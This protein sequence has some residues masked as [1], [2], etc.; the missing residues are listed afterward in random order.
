[1][2]HAANDR[3]VLVIGWDAAD[4]RVI[5]PMLA[6]GKL[7]NL[8]KLMDEGVHGNNSTLYPVLSPMLWTSIA[9][10][11]RPFKHGIHGFSEPTPDGSGVR[12]IT[13]ISRKTKAIWNILQQSGKR[14]VV[15]GWWP[16]HP[17]EPID[18]VMVSNHFQRAGGLKNTKIDPA[19]GKPAAGN[20]GWTNDQWPMSPG[21][22]HPPEMTRNLQEFRFHP[23]ELEF[24]HVAPFIPEIGKIDQ[25]KDKRLEGF[26]KTLADTVSIQG[27]S[28][29]LQQLEEWD[30]MCVYFDGIDH[31]CH[32]F[33]KY[34]PPRQE[35]VPE[36]DFELYKGV[37][38]GAYRFHDMMLG[39]T[40][41]LAGE[42]AT[43]I[44][45]SDHGFHPD[46]LRPQNIPT[47]PAGPAIE[48]R[49]YGI[50]VMKG[51]GI[52][53]GERIN[54]A[55]VLD[56]CPTVLTLFGLPVGLDMDGK[57]LVSAF[58]DPVEVRTIQSWDAVDGDC[59]MHPP[60]AHLD[61]MESADAIKQLVDLGYI[62][63]PDEDIGIA[64]RN[65]VQELKYNLARAYMDASLY[66]KAI[67]LLEEIWEQASEEHR[68]GLKLLTCLEAVGARDERARV[69]ERL[70]MNVRE[71]Q[72]LALAEFSGL[73]EEAAPHGVFLST[74]E[75]IEHPSGLSA[76]KWTAST[77]QLDPDTTY[78]EI[79]KKLAH[80]I[81]T[82]ATLLCPMRDVFNWL[83][84]SQ[85]LL[86]DDPK[87][88]TPFL[89]EMAKIKLNHPDL[90]LQVGTGFL[91]LDLH[92]DARMAFKRALDADSENAAAHLGI[93]RA[94]L[95]LGDLDPAVDHALHATEL[96]FFSPQSH[97]VLG[98][99]LARIGN[100]EMARAALDVALKQ[101]PGYHQAHLEMAELLES[102]FE[103]RE[104]A[105]AHRAAARAALDVASASEPD[106]H[107]EMDRII[108]EIAD[109]RAKRKT[110]AGNNE[111]WSMVPTDEIITIVSGLPRS[112]TSMMMQCLNAGGLQPFTDGERVADSDNPRGYF[113][114]EKAT[115]LGRDRSWLSKVRGK[116]VK[117]MAQL[118][119]MLPAD[120]KYRI[121]FM[122]RDLQEIA[123][124]QQAMLDRLGNSGSGLSDDR[125][126]RTFDAQ[127]A[128]VEAWMAESANIQCLFVDYSRTLD[129]PSS[130]MHE[131]NLFLGGSLDETM[132]KSAIDRSL[133]RQDSSD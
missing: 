86:G 36:E 124:S 39:A 26:A 47:E 66:R 22:V 51:P 6:E 32:G 7:P 110:A 46:H 93:A 63:E 90:H 79:P 61:A 92:E 105:E 60:D 64:V 116:S 21:T 53:R 131:V 129:D 82:R 117:I 11:K 118:L 130:I 70:Q 2:S 113:E 20:F 122:D 96:L 42:D 126:I 132:M 30:L 4:W 58:E 38:E 104:G 107:S 40:L 41:Q 88:A 102:G 99:A 31:F 83:H 133:R 95:A 19:I 56:L 9:T 33:M 12:P 77:E 81:R 8:K 94:S 57:P 43:V 120:Q 112:G 123:R 23:L 10:G 98:R 80:R 76:V 111:D 68:F 3:K 52:R 91:Q 17:A 84:A 101:A 78:E 108:Q 125:L 29:A 34:H 25:S 103:D 16:S 100:N 65:T 73:R 75:L 55:S 27:V 127:V 121:L 45:L 49:P 119:P 115:Q 37:V 14:S 54:G 35:H 18:G 62:D 15:V 59:G 87:Q 69:I 28:T 97:L 1:M 50:F 48:H 114:H 109:R 89:M 13:N 74:P 128:A 71:H 72:L 85:A 67:P 5:E 24:E 106:A 44:L